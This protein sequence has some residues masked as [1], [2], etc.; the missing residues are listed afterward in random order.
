VVRELE[1]QHVVLRADMGEDRLRAFSAS[2]GFRRPRLGDSFGLQRK[3]RAGRRALMRRLREI[4]GADHTVIM[5]QVENE[6]GMISEARDRSAAADGFFKQSVP[7]E[8]LDELQSRRESLIPEFREIWAASDY[9]SEGTW[10][11]VFGSGSHADEIFMAWHFARYVEQVITAGKA[12]YPLPHLIDVWR[13]GAPGVDFLSP[14]I[15]LPEFAVWCRRY[16]RSGNPLFI[17]EARRGPEAAVQALYAIGAHDAIGFAPFGIESID[18]PAFSLLAQSNDLVAQLTPLLAKHQG[19]SAMAG[20]LSGGAE[21][22]Q[23][24]RVHLGGYV[25]N[26][27]Y[28]Q[29]QAPAPA[30][31]RSNAT[32]TVPAG[33]LV[34]ATA[35]D[36]FVFAGIGLRITFNAPTPGDPII[37]ILSVEEGRYEDGRWVHTRWLNGDQT[38][39]GRH[40]RL[41]PGRFTTQRVKLYRYR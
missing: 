13:A 37:G 21:Q 41:N 12:E 39:Q 18:E 4:D 31:G 33:G 2:A 25:L 38:H 27:A 14:D 17:P 24:Q 9:R 30:D 10:E 8:L 20:L 11:D 6:I 16:A 36:E 34:V 22:R 28:E 35:P 26:V 1:E 19:K 7:R 32:T 3:Q 5:V 23:P 40:V 29:F 15:Y